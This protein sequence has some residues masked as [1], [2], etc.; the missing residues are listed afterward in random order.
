MKITLL[1]DIE[2]GEPAVGIPHFTD[3][4]TVAV[5]SGEPGGGVA[6]LAL[7]MGREAFPGYAPLPTRRPVSCNRWPGRGCSSRPDA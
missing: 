2:G 4:V 5:D 7:N 1:F 3:Q 6:P